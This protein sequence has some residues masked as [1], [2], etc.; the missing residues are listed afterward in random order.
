[1]AIAQNE[2]AQAYDSLQK[3]ILWDTVSDEVQMEAMKEMEQLLMAAPSHVLIFDN[4]RCI[5][6]GKHLGETAVERLTSI[7]R[8]IR[9]FESKVH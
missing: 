3:S 7:Q 6:S 1:M 2:I 5:A 9:R 4:G 8:R